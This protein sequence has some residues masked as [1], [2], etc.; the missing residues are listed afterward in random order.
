MGTQ[1]KELSI[2]VAG[3]GRY[4]QEREKE[5]RENEE[6]DGAFVDE[7]IL[8]VCRSIACNQT[9][10]YRKE[11][12]LVLSHISHSGKPATEAALALTRLLKKVR[13][14]TVLFVCVRVCVC[15]RARV[16][17]FLCATWLYFSHMMSSHFFVE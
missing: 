13:L 15:V 3:N 12:A 6:E 14:H 11:T 4:F 7:T 5:E 16:M 9:G 10:Y 8:P 17:H 2:I 1:S